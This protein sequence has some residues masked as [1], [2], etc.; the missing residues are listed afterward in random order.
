MNLSGKTFLVTGSSS[1]IGLA[2]ARRLLQEGAKVVGI[3]RRAEEAQLGEGYF[4]F[5]LD[6][7]EPETVPEALE[8]LG[9]RF[10]EIDGLLLAAGYGDFGSLEEFSYGRIRRLI[11]VNLLSQIYLCR[12]FVPCF[13]RKRRGDIVVIGSEAALRGGRYGAVY[14]ATKFALR[15]FVQSLRLECAARGVR[16]AIVNP[17]MT[18]TD[19]HRSL[20][21]EPGGEEHQ[22]LTPEDVAEA[23][24]L[25]LK[26]R[27]GCLIEEIN[28]SP[29]V[30]VVRKKAHRSGSTQ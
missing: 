8:R 16:V 22:H 5:S 10:L 7:A 4:P 26:A 23:V 11:E 30:H 21:F 20:N 18:A 28:L 9:K 1:G 12:H 13:K 24:L 29:L 15:G 14:S 19:F 17:G 25:I 27:E 2:I 3:A 6:L